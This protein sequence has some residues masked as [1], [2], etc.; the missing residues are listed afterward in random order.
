L[1]AALTLADI[2]RQRLAAA[3]ELYRFLGGGWN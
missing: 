2:K 3:V 1:A